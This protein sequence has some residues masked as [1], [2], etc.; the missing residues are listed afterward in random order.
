MREEKAVLFSLKLCEFVSCSLC[1]TSHIIG[2]GQVTEQL[3]HDVLSCGIFF[4]FIFNS[5]MGG[6]SIVFSLAVPLLLE[7]IVNSIASILFLIDSI[8]SMVYAEN[9]EH[10]MFLTDDEEHQHPFF[11][12]CRRQSTFA[13]LT[14]ALLSMHASLN[15]DMY[16]ISER[17]DDCENN[18]KQPITLHFLPFRICMWLRN[19]TNNQRIAALVQ[20]STSSEQS[21]TRIP[22]RVHPHRS[23]RIVR[24]AKRVQRMESSSEPQRME[25]SSEPTEQRVN[26][27]DQSM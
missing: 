6:L 13:M 17:I 18:A 9:D 24:R 1:L 22:H 7:A 16:F 3:P 12:T 8:I 10:L 23:R 20:R 15:W 14:S 19:R 21:D 25:S 4:C 27:V 2:V 5:L 26:H 11:I